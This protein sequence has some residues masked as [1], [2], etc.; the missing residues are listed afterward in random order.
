[1]TRRPTE[2]PPVARVDT[3]RETRF[4]VTMADPYRWME[5]ETGELRGWLAGQAAYADSILAALPGRA[6]LLARIAELTGR[7]SVDSA[8]RFGADRLFHLSQPAGAEVPVLM[9]HDG[10]GGAERVLLDPAA[11]AGDEHSHLDWYLPSPDGRHVACGI[12]QG[13]SEN[14]TLRVIEVD[15]GRLRD[16]AIPRTFHGAVSW[17]PDGAGFVYHRYLDPAPDTP[18]VERRRDSRNYLHRLADPPGQDTLVL[19]RGHNPLMPLS[20]RDRPFLVTPAGSD[21]MVAIIS[22][23]ALG[24]SIEEKLT[25]CSLYVA[26]RAGLADPAS[27]PWRRV[28]ERADGV[29]AYAVRGDTL[30]LVSHRDAPRSRVLAVSLADPDLSTATVIV[31][32][33]ERVVVAVRVVGEHLLVR[34]LDA[35][36]SRLRRVP[37]AGGQPQDVPLP[38]DGLIEEW[39]AHPGRAEALLVLSSWTVSPRVYRYDAAAGT[40]EDTGWVTSPVGLPDVEL[41]DL[42]VPVRDGTLVPLRVMHRK[43]LVLDGD[44]PT[45][46]TGYGSYG[47]VPRRLF[48]PEML[49]WYERGGVY[50]VAGIRG[51]G[52]YGR[53]W[54]EAGRGPNK[55]NT[56]TDFIDCAEYLVAHGYTRPGRLAGDGISAGGIPSGG[57]LVRR[58]ELWA[59]MVMRVPATNLTRMEFGENGPINIP[60]MGS[61][62]TETGLRDLLLV[63]A[64]LRVEDATAYP[65]VLLTA[66]RNDPRL[67]A[68]QPGK[69]AARLQAATTSGRPVLLRVDAHAGHGH[70][71]TRHQ[72]DALTADMLAFLLH[73]FTVE[74]HP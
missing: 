18:P 71:S 67:P 65:A 66:G 64:Y 9:V 63:D 16:E 14:S 24:A 12:S 11:L 54:H 32:S 21:W 30:F 4:G 44:N 45:L 10:E 50:A 61:V 7:A 72:R 69:M 68:W 3:V 26:P 37:L 73:A 74:D 62:T 70:G 20:P 53:E 6:E 8:F 19:A 47:F 22:H 60:E 17:T 58:P 35:G 25:D 38:V 28:A 40:V 41:A 48:M 42:R 27:C 56:I 2:R 13:G 59:A 57:A 33:G 1:M 39:T 36:F 49:P 46:L 52:E 15:S 31:P 51:G 43:G 23:S 55:E 29:T 34:D 5:D